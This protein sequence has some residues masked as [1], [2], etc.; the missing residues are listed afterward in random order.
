MNTDLIASCLE[1][2]TYKPGWTFTA[3]QHDTE[4]PTI[5]IEVGVEDSTTPG[6][7]TLLRIRTF[8]PPCRT[9]AD[10][11]RWLRYRLQ[12]IEAHECDEWF[13]VDGVQLHNPHRD[14]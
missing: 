14:I 12:R 3:G 8:V 1:R 11:Y 4:G 2:F 7:Y 9:P 10:F 13:R 5:T 6:T